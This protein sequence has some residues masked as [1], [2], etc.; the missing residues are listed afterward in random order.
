MSYRSLDPRLIIETAERLEAR[1]ADRFPESELRK[2]GRELVS[3]ARD[4][5]DAATELQRPILWLRV[6]VGVVFAAG[7]GVFLFVGTVLPFD[8][9]SS[10]GDV[11]ESVQGIEASINTVVLAV[12]G[13]L[14]L[15]HAEDRIKRRRVFR[16]LHGLRS[17]I[18]VIDMHQL[19][20]DPSALSPGFIPAP[21]SPKRTM[22]KSDLLRYLDYCSE[23]LSITGKL[24]AL[25]AQ[26][27]NDEVVIEAVNDVE[28][29]GSNLSRKIW[30]KITMLD[31]EGRTAR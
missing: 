4:T 3:L 20:K 27:V 7:A 26:S 11:V 16:Q 8:R 24:A 23:M 29:L 22:S 10:G 31:A 21:H 9:F 28:N 25:F 5:R 1:I 19:T 18:H 30:Q 13:I 17:L 14:A 6:L 15:V 12:L 2:V